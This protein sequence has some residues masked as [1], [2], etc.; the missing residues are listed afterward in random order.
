MSKGFEK[1]ADLANRNNKIRYRKVRYNKPEQFVTDA[2]GNQVD[3]AVAPRIRD[4]GAK[5]LKKNFSDEASY[6]AALNT[7]KADKA[8]AQAE[9]KAAQSQHMAYRGNLDNYNNASF[10]LG[11]TGYAADAALDNAGRVGKAALNNKKTVLA[12]AAG[13]PVVDYALSDED[14]DDWDITD[15]FSPSSLAVDAGIG[16][17]VGALAGTGATIGATTAIAPMVGLGAGYGAGRLID[18][19]TGGALSS[20]VSKFGDWTSGLDE[21]YDNQRNALTSSATSPEYLKQVKWL[22]QRNGLMEKYGISRMEANDIMEGRKEMPSVDEVIAH[23]DDPTGDDPNYI[24]TASESTTS[25]EA[26]PFDADAVAKE[27]IRNRYGAG[28]NRRKALAEAGYT[29]EQIAL[30]QQRVNQMMRPSDG[31]RPVDSVIANKPIASSIPSAAMAY[32]QA[33]NSPQPV[34]LPQQAYA[35]SGYATGHEVYYDPMR[36]FQYR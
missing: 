20:G 10:R 1:L 32:Q 18:N 35:P 19:A 23:S 4:V 30:A 26:S 34:N 7:W 31:R 33:Y 11:N 17:G 27:I 14:L 16:A 29:P 22:N 24:T 36:G 28:A 5:P 12:T 9:Y 2:A 8:A 15:L 3:L 6:N 25:S 21:I 13:V